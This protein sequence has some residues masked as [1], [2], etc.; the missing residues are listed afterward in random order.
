[1]PLQ[2]VVAEAGWDG[3]ENTSKSIRGSP[4]PGSQVSTGGLAGHGR[5]RGGESVCTGQC[6]R[7]WHA[8]TVT[9]THP[10]AT[11]HLASA[12]ARSAQSAT[13][14]AMGSRARIV[15]VLQR[16]SPDCHPRVPIGQQWW[17]ETG[18][19]RGGRVQWD[20]EQ[21]TCAIF[22]SRRVEVGDLARGTAGKL[23]GRKARELLGGQFCS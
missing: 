12:P 4:N 13:S 3:W 2:G 5:P 10:H 7:G 8:M 19:E 21:G 9:I 6:M 1:M 18:F 15:A 23:A 14:A 11:P 22:A 17:R 20:N 16:C